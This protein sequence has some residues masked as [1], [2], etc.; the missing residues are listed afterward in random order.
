MLYYGLQITCDKRAKTMCIVGSSW[1]I[2]ASGPILYQSCI[3]LSLPFHRRKMSATPIDTSPVVHAT[4]THNSRYLSISICD[5]Y[6]RVC[7]TREGLGRAE[8]HVWSAQA[9]TSLLLNQF[10]YQSRLS[11]EYY[12]STDGKCAPRQS[13]PLQ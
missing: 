9:G 10:F 1:Y 13:I 3:E 11:I 8:M 12:D 2:L 6:P 4:T 5:D 7:I